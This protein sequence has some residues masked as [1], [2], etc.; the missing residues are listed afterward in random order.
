VVWGQL[1]QGWE[2]FRWVQPQTEVQWVQAVVQLQTV[3]A[4]RQVFV[5]IIL[6]FV[7]LM[8]LL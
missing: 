1:P 3:E 7:V 6:L 2:L 5:L 4:Y 8:V